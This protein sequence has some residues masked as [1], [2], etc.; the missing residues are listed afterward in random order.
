MEPQIVATE[1][2]VHLLQITDTHLFA[3]AEGSLLGVNTEQSFQAVVDSILQHE[4]AFEAILATGD[5]SQDHTEA[6]YIKF[7]Q[8]I[9]KL[10][11]PCFWLPG[12]HDYK[13]SMDAVFPSSQIMEVP[14]VLAGEH[15]QII[16]LD[17]QVEGLPHGFLEN[18]Q[19]CLLD[20]KLRQYPQRHALVLLHHNALPIGSAWLDQHR[21]QRAN[22]FWDVLRRHDNVRAVLG[23]HV[24]QN[25]EKNHQDVQVMATP[26]T[27]I[28]FKANNDE[29]AL[30]TLSPGWRYLQLH[31]DGT[32]SS[33]VCRLPEGSFVPDFESDG[34]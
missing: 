24:H 19:L 26:S 15:W 5:I 14:H 11:K 30:D 29:F 7:A 10:K 18:E 2:T 33:Q 21:L 4:M 23:G 9:Q 6:S 8:G 25:F 3:D 22:L 32:L 17:S 16:L 20:E 34:Y 12:N 31:R 27:C 28:Q 1:E 13:P